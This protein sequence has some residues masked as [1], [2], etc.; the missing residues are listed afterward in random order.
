MGT[1]RRAT[2]TGLFAAWLA[3]LTAGAAGQTTSIAT[4]TESQ[5]ERPAEAEVATPARKA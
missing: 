5:V 3:P 4:E 2:V 1:I